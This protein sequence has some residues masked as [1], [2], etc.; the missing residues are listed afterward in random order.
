MNLGVKENHSVSSTDSRFILIPQR[1]AVTRRVNQAI[2][3]AKRSIDFIVSS[4]R[5]LAGSCDKIPENYM[6]V[7]VKCRYVI[8]Q[9]LSQSGLETAIKF[10][11]KS[12]CAIR[13]IT[14]HPEAVLGIYDRREII[15]IEDPKAN[16]NCSP[17]LWTNNKSIISLAQYYFD[18]LW[19]NSSDNPHLKLKK[20]VIKPTFECPPQRQRM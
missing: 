13:F 3:E 7:N 10:K 9:P 20:A 12:A 5:F 19:D 8:E 1:E 4:K 11:Q 18:I 16:L 14:T 6:N 15:L 17:A 2:S